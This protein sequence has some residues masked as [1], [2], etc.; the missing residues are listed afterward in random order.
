MQNK[1]IIALSAGV[2]EEAEAGFARCSG[3]VVGAVPLLK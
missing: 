2:A 3:G 1:R